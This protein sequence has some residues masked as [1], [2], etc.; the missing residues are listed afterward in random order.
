MRRYVPMIKKKTET[1]KKLLIFSSILS[2]VITICTITAVFV[3]GDTSPL[4]FLIVGA[5]GLT[6]T[7]YGFYF[8]KAKNE[9][10]KKYGYKELR[11][12]D[13]EDYSG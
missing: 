1:S 3:V 12:D 4:E 13:N 5:F 8:W 6:S 9:N 10:I 11:G 7:C 2:I